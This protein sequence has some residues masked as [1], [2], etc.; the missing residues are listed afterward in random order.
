MV[1]SLVACGEGF[2]ITNARPHNR[3]SLGGVPLS[4][5]AL[6]S[7]LR[8]LTYGLALLKAGVGHG[9]GKRYST[10]AGAC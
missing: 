9:Q 5:L 7:D 1:R 8:P 6:E 10:S 4:Y 3:S 2:G